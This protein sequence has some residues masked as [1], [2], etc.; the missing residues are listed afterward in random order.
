MGRKRGRNQILL[1]MRVFRFLV[2]ILCGAIAFGG[3][4]KE[5]LTAENAKKS[6]KER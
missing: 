2:A 5:L 1:S 6:R 3:V 4:G